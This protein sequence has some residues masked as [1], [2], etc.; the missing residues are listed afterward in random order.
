MERRNCE[1]RSGAML[2]KVEDDGIVQWTI[3]K[4][5]QRDRAETSD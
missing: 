1:R 3:D 5:S 4:L 2:T